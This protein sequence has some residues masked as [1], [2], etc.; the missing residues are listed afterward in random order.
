MYSRIAT[1]LYVEFQFWSKFHRKLIKLRF[2]Y[3]VKLC[4]LCGGQ[5]SPRILYILCN[6]CRKCVNIVL[7]LFEFENES[8]QNR[9]NSDPLTETMV[10]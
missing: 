3:R 2:C 6:K 10:W 8:L 5:P 9:K 1:G 4:F 7:S